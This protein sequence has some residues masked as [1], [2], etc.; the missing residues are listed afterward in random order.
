MLSELLE[1]NANSI[2]EVIAE[3]RTLLDEHGHHVTASTQ[4]RFATPTA[5]RDFLH[6]IPAAGAEP[7]PQLPEGLSLPTLTGMTRQELD[8][9]I[10]RLAPRQAALVERHRH[11]RRG[12]E[13]MPGG[14]G[15][16]F[17]QKI[18]D[19]E[20]VLATVLHQRKLCTRAA[21][22]ELFGV[23]PRTIGTA[24][25]QVRPLLD[26]DQVTITPAATRYRTAADLLAAIPPPDIAA[27]NSTL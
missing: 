24:L 26:Q 27:A 2:G 25:L 9:L 8:D 19:A 13:R 5:L 4:L 1:V 12:G 14:R 17:L 21:L 10:G 18:S 7:P 23:S 3:T 22:A 16:V 15:G 6:Q 11:S 20:R